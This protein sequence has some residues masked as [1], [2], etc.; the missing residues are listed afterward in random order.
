MCQVTIDNNDDACPV[1]VPPVTQ[2]KVT[3]D[4]KDENNG[5]TASQGSSVHIGNILEENKKR[6]RSK[7]HKSTLQH[8]NIFFR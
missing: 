6:Q 1:P 8:L 5:P 4:P 2:D 3:N 7:M